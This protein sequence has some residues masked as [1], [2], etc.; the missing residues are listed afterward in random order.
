M[1]KGLTNKELE[2]LLAAF[3]GRH[4]HLEGSLCADLGIRLMN[5][6]GKIA[7]FVHRWFTRRGVLQSSQSMTASS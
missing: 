5:T 2:A 4:P 3:T 7:E 6:D 1:A